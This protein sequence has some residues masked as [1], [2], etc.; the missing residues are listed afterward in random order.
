MSEPLFDLGPVRLTFGAIAA[1]Q[2]NK[3]TEEPLL[4]RHVSGDWGVVSQG[5][6]EANDEALQSG[7]QLLSSY[8]LPDETKVWVL[9]DIE[10]DAEHHR[11]ITTVLL[12]EEN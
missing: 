4:A 8:L 1:L 6:K 3:M 12:P 2:R 9:T 7:E 10:I 5:D 11:K